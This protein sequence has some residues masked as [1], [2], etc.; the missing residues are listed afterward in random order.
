VIRIRLASFDDANA[1]RD[2]HARNGMGNLDVTVWRESWERYPF[3]AEFQG[4]PIGWVLENDGGLVVGSLDNIHTLYE[5]EGR[6]LKGAVASAW[7]VDPEHRGKSLQ[8]MTAF[9][10]QPGI[11]LWLNVSASPAAARILTA[12]K[13]GRIP[14]P[15][16]SRPCFWA[17]YPWRFAKA[18]LL[19][20]SIP[21]AGMLARP[22]GWAMLARDI[23]RGSGQG[24]RYSEVQRLSG[25]DDRFDGLWK[26]LSCGEKRLRAVRTK[27]V[28]EW[29]FRTELRSGRA[30][31]L[32]AER[33]GDL[34]GYA[35]LTRR[36]DAEM[37][38]YDLVD[39]Q[40]ADE[41]TSTIKDLLLGSIAIA[42][43]H[44]ADAL[45]FM[46]GMPVKRAAAE[47]LWPYTY[48]LP[49]WQ[50]YFK[51]ASPELATALSTPDAWDF[52]WFDSF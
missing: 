48:R 40:V 49:L 18:A 25:F 28:L 8:L 16:Y 42:R 47:E 45:K 15:D 31:I 41:T 21:G 1:I 13:I 2:L 4:I 3:R 36:I 12:M 39:L 26:K 19:R 35:V 34:L 23:F 43:Q 50:Q 6:R 29:R 51:A 46:T 52:S 32:A 17:I 24:R 14:I 20:R 10:R 37:N 9:F 38:L 44:G 5:L 22:I 7:V 11:D 33:A 30:V 27:E